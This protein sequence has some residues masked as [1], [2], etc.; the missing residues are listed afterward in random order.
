[1]SQKSD[2]CRCANIEY[3]PQNE[4]GTK[5]FYLEN[6][7][8]IYGYARERKRLLWH[9]IS[10]SLSTTSPAHLIVLGAG[11]RLYRHL[12]ETLVRIVD[13]GVGVEGGVVHAEQAAAPALL[14]LET[15]VGLPRHLS[16]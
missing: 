9:F 5:M 13:V 14:I 12:A 7:L 10:A 11:Q 8:P 16:G 2:R 6:V 15:R 4:N 1:M 3:L